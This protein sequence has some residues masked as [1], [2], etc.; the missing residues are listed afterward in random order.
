MNERRIVWYSGWVQGVGFRHTTRAVAQR[1]NVTGYVKNL[2]DGRVVVE[3][4]GEA[5]ELD[6]F[7]TDLEDRMGAYI[8]GKE[9]ERGQAAG[10]FSG[11]C[12]RY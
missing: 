11:F 3:A 7:F 4:E 12:I 2:P 6:R 1:Y 8:E 5:A 10:Q 9:E